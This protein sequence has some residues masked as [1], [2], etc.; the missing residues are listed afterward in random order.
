[1]VQRNLRE[2]HDC[3]HWSIA[4]YNKRCSVTLRRQ[5]IFGTQMCESCDKKL[6]VRG[7]LEYHMIV[8]TGEE[9]IIIKDALSHSGEKPFSGP[10]FVN[11]VTKSS[12]QEE[13]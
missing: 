2:S 8:H 7:I 6:I 1:M 11:Y 10:G 13:S 12:Y 5:A 4:Y 3:S 9:P